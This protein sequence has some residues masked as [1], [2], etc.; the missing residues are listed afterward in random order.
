[1]RKRPYPGGNPSG[2]PASAGIHV[3]QKK[4]LQSI[5]EARAGKRLGSLR[6]LNSYWV[7][8][9]AKYK[10]YEVIFVDPFHEAIRM[11]PQIN[12]IAHAKHKHR[13]MRGKTSAGRRARGLHGKA[14][15][16]EM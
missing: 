11:D 16:S 6:L 15:P 1:M 13:E 3:T 5:A 10:W 8:Q 12:W 2:K 4:N 9:D 7:N 14:R